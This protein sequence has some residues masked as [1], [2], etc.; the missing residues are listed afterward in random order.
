MK[1]P[2]IELRNRDKG[3]SLVEVLFGLSLAAFGMLAMGQLFFS[4]ASSLNLARSK[5]TA[6]LAARNKLEYLS[7]LYFQ[8]S[9]HADLAPGSH[10]PEEVPVIN[11][12]DDSV[13]DLFRIT[14]SI[15][16]IVDPRPDNAPVAIEVKVAAKPIRNDGTEIN[17][18]Y[19]NRTV[20]LTAI[21]G[22]QIQ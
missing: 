22:P 11:P 6:V 18:P 16:S 15:G 9:L 10:G 8:N 12:I 4:T 14:W 21:L 20:Q 19:F 13:L 2:T 7:D 5:E 1:H 17:S 3:F